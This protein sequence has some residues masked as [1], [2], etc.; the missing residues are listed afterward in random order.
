MKLQ[1]EVP[2][3]YLT[4]LT[5]LQLINAIQDFLEE[6]KP[7]PICEGSGW[8]TPAGEGEHE[9]NECHCPRCHGEKWEDP[10]EN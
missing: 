4:E 3:E 6:H 5:E 9:Q 10:F 8:V 7:C 1:I 2:S